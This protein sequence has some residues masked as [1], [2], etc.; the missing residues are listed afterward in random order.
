MAKNVMDLTEYLHR[1]KLAGA[2]KSKSKS[3]YHNER[4]VVDGRTF[5]SKKEAKVYQQLKLMQIGGQIENFKC[6]VT[7]PLFAYDPE[8]AAGRKLCAYRAD[9]VVRFKDG[10]E[11]VWD[12]KGFKTREYML[13]KKLLAANYGIHIV[14]V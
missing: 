13:K 6:Q 9:F 1:Q 10:R 5:D 2:A 14:E 4:V 3:K 8:L 11:Q 7:Y 12:A